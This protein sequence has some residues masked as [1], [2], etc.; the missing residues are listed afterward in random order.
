MRRVLVV[1]G[2]SLLVL[3]LIPYWGSEDYFGIKRVREFGLGFDLYRL[4]VVE[5]GHAGQGDWSELGR[6]T[7][8]EP[9]GVST[10]LLLLGA[11]AM[12][13][14]K[15]MTRGSRKRLSET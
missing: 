14:A 5:S 8:F 1:V 6:L 12:T 13:G 2:A 9:L 7:N 4:R 10:L 15:F 3:A 11:T